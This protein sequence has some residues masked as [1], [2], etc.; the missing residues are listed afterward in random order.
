MKTYSVSKGVGKAAIQ[1]LTVAGALIA[2]AGFS[3]LQLWD[4]VVTY[5]KP[6]IGSL[7]VGGVIAFAINYVKF[8]TSAD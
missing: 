7:T 1:L 3:D 5:V 6:V 8:H 4:L 2:F